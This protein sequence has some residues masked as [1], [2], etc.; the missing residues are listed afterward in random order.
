MNATI[1]LPMAESDRAGRD[2]LELLTTL[3]NGPSFDPLF[4]RDVIRIPSDHPVYP[5]QCV[6]ADC[7]R[8]R[9]ATGD[10]CA[11]HRAQWNKAKAAGTRRAAFVRSALPL[12][13][14]VSLEPIICR[15]CVHRPAFNRQ[16]ALCHRHRNRWRA[17]VRTHGT[18]TGFERWLKTQTPYPTYGECR[19]GACLELATS[20]LGLCV[21]H[22]DR[23]GDV[24]KPGGATLPRGWFGSYEY[25][26]KPVPV[27]Y[28]DESAFRR[29]CAAQV[30][31]MRI[32]DLNLRGLRPLL[33]AE[34]RWGL[35]AH[36]Q[37][38]Q[39]QAWELPWLQP[40]WNSATTDVLSRCSTSTLPAA[41]KTTSDG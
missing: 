7:E 12:T 21:L 24:G 4:C 29:W 2:R 16:L 3:I 22:E 37:G 26:D 5:W 13:R 38:E 17:H 15:I 33:R 27:R 14:T 36:V 30:P 25:H 9:W 32:G 34:I 1:P 23:Y 19:T 6:V 11:I 10:L 40:C 20:P 41:R 31:V 8:S 35:H 39:R 28:D 18:K